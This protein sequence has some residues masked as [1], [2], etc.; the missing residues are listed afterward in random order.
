METVMNL[1]QPR[2]S[3]RM[4]K[5]VSLI[6]LFVLLSGCGEVGKAKAYKIR[7]QVQRT[8][9]AHRATMAERAT[10]APTRIAA[11]ENLIFSGAVA[12]IVLIVA[13]TGSMSYYII[14]VSVA[15]V[16]KADVMQIPLDKHT[17]QY[18]LLITG[19]KRAYNPNT[20][21]AGDLDV[22][23]LP[24]PETLRGSQAVQMIGAGGEPRYK[25][26][27]EWEG[28]LLPE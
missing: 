24:H 27:S 13:L 9:D 6:F 2:G 11:K 3:D 5:V 12:G 16:K 7:S 8:N 26:Y 25:S 1:F 20:L 21:A 10:L 17:K 19:G 28:R 22:I 14:G 23:Q 18:P 15:K 4:R